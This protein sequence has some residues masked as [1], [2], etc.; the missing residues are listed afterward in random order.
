LLWSDAYGKLCEVLTKN[1]LTAAI[2]K[3]SPDGQTSCLEGYHSVINQFAPKMLSFSY[4]GML[5][6]YNPFYIG[7]G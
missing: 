6:R 2:K 3:A 5:A 4:Q 7:C 1:N